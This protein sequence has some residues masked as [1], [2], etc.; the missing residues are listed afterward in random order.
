MSEHND[1]IDVADHVLHPPGFFGLVAWR[2]DRQPDRAP[3]SGTDEDRRSG[4][5]PHS[6]RLPE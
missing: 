4:R 5:S 6:G 2:L 1:A 3:S